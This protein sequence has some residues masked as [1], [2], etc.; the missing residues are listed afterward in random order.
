MAVADDDSERLE[1]V[2]AVAVNVGWLRDEDWVPDIPEKDRKG[3][4]NR[5][6]NKV[7]NN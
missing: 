1:V 3:R 5:R 7:V 2:I 6:E 4:E